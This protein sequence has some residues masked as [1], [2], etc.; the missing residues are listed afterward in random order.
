MSFI[1][2]SEHTELITSPIKLQYDVDAVEAAFG[3]STR[4]V[5]I[6]KI[7]SLTKGEIIFCKVK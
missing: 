4:V 5:A 6:L 2:S 1:F 7:G 3:H